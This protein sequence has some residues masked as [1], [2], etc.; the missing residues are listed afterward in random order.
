VSRS[1]RPAHLLL[2]LFGLLTAATV[3]A[4]QSQTSLKACA[5]IADPSQRLDC[6]DRLAGRSTTA[7]SAPAAPPSAPPAAAAAAPAAPASA[8]PGA[9]STAS[10][11]PAS[12][13]PAAQT[14][15]GQPSFGLYPA[16]HPKPP[17]PASSLETHVLSLGRSVSGRTTVELDGGAVWELDEPD[18]L[19]AVGDTVTITR[20]L[21]GSFLMQTPSHRTH[22][23]RR[24]H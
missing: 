23:V 4:Q 3:S 8:S 20:A 1:C 7:T 19:L 24:L 12:A 22:R 13:A 11:A 15:P 6:Y 9:G 16:E 14:P 10:G 17:A 18:P 2:P 21:L 5:A